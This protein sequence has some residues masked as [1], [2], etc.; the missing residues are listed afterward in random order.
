MREIILIQMSGADRDGLLAGIMGQLAAFGV[1][2]LDISQSVIH[3][4]LSFGVL[5]EVPREHESSPILK[6]LL[7]WSHNQGLNLKF[8]PVTEDDYERWVG[9]QGRRRHIVT[10]LGR[11]LTAAN[12]AAMSEV[13][14]ANGL[15]VDCIT[16]LSGRRSLAKPPAMPR[17]CVEFSVR[18]T[19]R[20][21]S[22]MRA[23]FL[24][25]S[26]EQGIDIGFQ[27]DNA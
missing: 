25:L 1:T 7:F 12:L 16:R 13:I 6:D 4:D 24:D 5:I 11:T 3:D 10:V 8:S 26:R 21:I 20:D 19:P 17:A 23:A 14:T 22:A 2:V 9:M 27:E 18:G 15:S